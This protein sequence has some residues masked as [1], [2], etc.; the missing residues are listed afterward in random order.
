MRESR[1]ARKFAKDIGTYND[2]A[3]GADPADPGTIDESLSQ[4]GCA[5]RYRGNFLV[6][7]SP[8]ASSQPG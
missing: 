4:F 5:R 2:S 7:D 1:D 3:S 8:R 6:H